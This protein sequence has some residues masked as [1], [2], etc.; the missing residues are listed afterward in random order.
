MEHILFSLESLLKMKSINGPVLLYKS[1]FVIIFHC[2]HGNV[3][4]DLYMPKPTSN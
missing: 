3:L 4:A 1:K 2:P